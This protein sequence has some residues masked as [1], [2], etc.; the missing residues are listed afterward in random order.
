MLL[1]YM[2]LALPE[3][4][5][6][7]PHASDV[8]QLSLLPQVSEADETPGVPVVPVA[9]LPVA[10][11]VSAAVPAPADAALAAEA[12]ARKGPSEFDTI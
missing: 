4:Q 12:R 2:L 10:G 7:S 5:Q 9:V 1:I 11:A 8:L 3:D 6:A